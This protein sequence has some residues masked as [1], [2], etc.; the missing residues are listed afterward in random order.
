MIKDFLMDRIELLDDRIK[1][2]ALELLSNLVDGK[3]QNQLE[4]ILLD[5]IG[6]F[7]EDDA[8]ETN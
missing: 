5:D 8:N 6:Q 7:L 2:L 4:E 3:S 1:F